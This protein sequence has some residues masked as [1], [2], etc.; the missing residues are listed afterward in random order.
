MG[1]NAYPIKPDDNSKH[2]LRTLLSILAKQRKALVVFNCFLFLV[3]CNTLH[4]LKKSSDADF[5][6][7]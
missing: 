3:D 1:L 5:H 6:N 7:L 4:H 2:T